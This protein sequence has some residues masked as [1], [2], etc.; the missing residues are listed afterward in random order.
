MSNKILIP[1]LFLAI[2]LAGCGATTVENTEQMDDM[3]STSSQAM[4]DTKGQSEEDDDGE[5]APQQSSLTFIG[6]SSIVDHEGGFSDFSISLTESDIPEEAVLVA[7]V[8][9][10]SIYSDSDRLT[11]HLKAEDFFDA[12]NYPEASFTSTSIVKVDGEDMYEVTGDLTVKGVT[13]TVT[14]NAVIDD[15]YIKLTYDLPRKEFGIGNDSYGDKLLDE[16]IP[17]VAVVTL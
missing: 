13:K 15:D 11:E 1:S 9:I 2:L 3:G 6:G 17:V 5:P 16:T 4:D 10:D 8:V 7:N 12:D 14:I